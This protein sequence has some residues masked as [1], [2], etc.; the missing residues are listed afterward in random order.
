MSRKFSQI[1]SAFSSVRNTKAFKI[2]LIILIILAI[3]V[4]V[5]LNQRVNDIR[6]R[7]SGLPVT[8]P[9]LTASVVFY[10]E[11]KTVAVGEVFDVLVTIHP[12]MYRIT[13]IDMKIVFNPNLELVSFIPANNSLNSILKNKIMNTEGYLEFSATNTSD[14]L[15]NAEYQAIDLGKLTFRAKI[16][17]S[18]YLSYQKLN[19]TALNQDT[20]LQGIASK[21]GFYTVAVDITTTPTPTLAQGTVPVCVASSIPPQAGPAPLKVTLHGGGQAGGSDSGIVG[22]MWDFEN[23]GVWDTSV[24]INPVTHVYQQPGDYTPKYQIL[25]TN[26]KWSN[27]CNYAYTVK[28][29]TS[30]TPV[31]VGDINKDKSV[32]IL[33]YNIWRSEYLG[34]ETT[35]LSDL[36]FDAVIDLLD[37]NIW[38]NIFS[39]SFSTTPTPVLPTGG[40]ESL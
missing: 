20:Y 3:P 7:A 23:D 5:I 18:T 26:G 40:Q 31:L 4:T 33:D 9:T 27:I 21:S 38:R 24:D 22:Y 28:V 11:Q 29:G 8:S 35:R 37:F 34:L 14:D 30:P 19:I 15:L 12:E 1:K 17:G 13:G 10:P 32:D 2:I 6:Q 16:E 39:K 25:G 36:N